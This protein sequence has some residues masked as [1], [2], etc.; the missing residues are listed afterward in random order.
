MRVDI[1]GQS[2]PDPTRVLAGCIRVDISG[3]WLDTFI[4]KGYT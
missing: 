4:E 3:R 2:D 1:N